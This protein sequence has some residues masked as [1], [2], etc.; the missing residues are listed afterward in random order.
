MRDLARRA[1]D[2]IQVRALA[3]SLGNPRAIESYIR[4]N[5]RIVPDPSAFEFIRDVPLQ[6]EIAQTLGVLE[7]DCDDA[8]TIAAS[9]LFALGYPCWLIAIRLPGETDFSHVFVSC[10]VGGELLDIDPI[11]PLE[12]L[13]IRGVEEVL[14]VEL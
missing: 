6:L 12:S 13:P 5:W 1:A 11:V 9:L 14:G 3:E 10:L 8:A 4:D 2:L 7:G